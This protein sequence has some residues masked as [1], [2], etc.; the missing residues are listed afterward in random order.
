MPHLRPHLKSPDHLPPAELDQL[1][2]GGWRPMGQQVYISD[3]ALLADGQLHSTLCTRLP[4]EGY[5]FSKSLR[6]L[7][8]RN[9]R[10]FQT[11]IGPG[12]ITALHREVNHRYGE[13]FPDRYYP[14]LAFHLYNQAGRR[15]LDTRQVEVYEGSR[16]VAFSFFDVGT[17]SLYSKIGI[18]DP[19]YRQASLG[20]YTMLKEVEW[21]LAHHRS[22]YYPGYVVPGYPGFDYK[23]RI[24]A[25]EY[26]AIR[27]GAWRPYAGLTA[28]DIPLS[29]IRDRLAKL[30]L[31]FRQYGIPHDTYDN[32]FFDLGLLYDLNQLPVLSHP[33]FLVVGEE[34]GPHPPP[35]VVIFD[36]FTGAYEW[37]RCRYLS[38]ML[39]AHPI[40]AP[41]L[42]KV[43]LREK[44][45]LKTSDPAELALAV[46]Y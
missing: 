9:D 19:H 13:Q 39:P 33:V 37:L 15:V 21:A 22:Y 36:Y 7:R 6:Q 11:H 3:Y 32:P 1:L 27:S 5:R 2:A 25:L 46:R 8:R 29:V 31:I 30:S 10:Q 24:G 23:H 44:S 12:R 38:G 4:L 41:H 26:L 43:L 45:L 14:D 34:K 16:L 17:T 40:R 28:A 35:N 20:I 42:K 18:Y